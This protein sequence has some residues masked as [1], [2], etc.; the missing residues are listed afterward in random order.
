MQ[1]KKPRTQGDDHAEETDLVLVEVGS[2]T[3]L[4]KCSLR[5][6]NGAVFAFTY[7]VD[8]EPAPVKNAGA[9]AGDYLLV[10][11]KRSSNW[12]PMTVVTTWDKYELFAKAK[13]N[14]L[15]YADWPGVLMPDYSFFKHVMTPGKL[16]TLDTFLIRK[17]HVSS[18]LTTGS[19]KKKKNHTYRS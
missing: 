12:G 7:V 10:A 15:A 16:A 11:G 13:S 8:P 9:V 1:P 5:D 3:K 14:N 19:K 2:F 17:G 18:V 4:Q 6:G